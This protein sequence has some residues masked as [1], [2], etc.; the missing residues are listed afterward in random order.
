MADLPKVGQPKGEWLSARSRDVQ[1]GP[2]TL[3]NEQEPWVL[4]TLDK[5]WCSLRLTPTQH[6]EMR[7]LC[8]YLALLIFFHPQTQELSFY[9]KQR[10]LHFNPDPFPHSALPGQSAGRE[11]T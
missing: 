10:G 7:V 3:G 2:T 11:K 1:F 8:L 9:S 6:A 5:M 4:D